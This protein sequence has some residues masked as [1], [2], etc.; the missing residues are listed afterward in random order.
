MEITEELREALG[1][2]LDRAHEDLESYQTYGNP[3]SDYG[4]DW[5][6]AARLQAGYCRA[7]GQIAAEAGLY[8]EER[9][10]GMAEAL[11]ASAKE[12]EEDRATKR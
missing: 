5:P 10:N 11:E 3:H 2:V 7:V 1:W 6:D 8:D 4:D 9:W 12:Y